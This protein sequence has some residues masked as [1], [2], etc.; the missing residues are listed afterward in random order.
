[1]KEMVYG[2]IRENEILYSGEYKGFDIAIVNRGTHPCAY[3]RMPDDM[4]EKLKAE[5]PDTYDDY[6]SYYGNVHGGYTYCRY[7]NVG[8]EELKTGLWLGWD[9]AHAGDYYWCLGELP[10]SGEKKWTVG[11]ILATAFE[12]VDT[13]EFDDSFSRTKYEDI[14]YEKEPERKWIPCSDPSD[15]P[16][17]KKL[18][19][20]RE[21]SYGSFTF[22][23]VSCVIWDMTEWSDSVSNV[24]AYMPYWEPEPYTE[25]CEE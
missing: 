17:D 21:L 18:W 12:A 15:L 22:R 14:D 10:E 24:V 19:I 1:M 11:E 6:D 4:M 2:A 9:Y 16:K 7:G 13:L 8:F 20:T 25:G 3:I 5:H 23:E